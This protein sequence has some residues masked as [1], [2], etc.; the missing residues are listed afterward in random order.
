[1]LFSTSIPD[2]L[3]EHP[4][5]LAFT[6]VFDKLQNF[7]TEVIA[8][9]LRVH[10]PAILMNKKWLIKKLDEYGVSDMPL[11]YPI[12]IMA[13]YLLNVDAVCR[14]RGSKIGLELYCSLLSFGEVTI[15]DNDFY[16]EPLWLILDSDT[17]GFITED[18]RKNSYRL[19]DNTDVFKQSSCLTITIK[20]I[21][22]NGKHPN[23]AKVIKLYIE[24]TINKQLGFSPGKNITFKYQ[25]R[26][27]PYYHSLLNPY[28][29]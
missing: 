14:T 18:N 2:K 6:T 7:K 9:Y 1:M 27:K 26:T 13:Q 21:Y 19:C 23:E 3:Q 16:T 29:V 20:S 12:S 15:D 28:F 25:S 5:A 8:E 24:N 17:Q 4:N 11:E 10:N 22:F